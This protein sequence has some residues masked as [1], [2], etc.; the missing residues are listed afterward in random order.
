MVKQK[1]RNI[2]S[3]KNQEDLDHV[4][5]LISASAYKPD[6]I[7]VESYFSQKNQLNA[8][9]QLYLNNKYNLFTDTVKMH[10]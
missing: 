5:S 6:Q 3:Q 2:L 10:G 8:H 4:T 7:F 9:Y 1:D